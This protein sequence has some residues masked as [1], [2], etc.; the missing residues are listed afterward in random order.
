M[1]PVYVILAEG[2]EEIE[3]LTVVDI[4]RRG[5]VFVSTVSNTE[6]KFVAG[7]HQI[8]VKADLI[9]SEMKEEE[10]LAIV[11]PGG[12]PGTI[13]L[14]ENEKLM[15]M[16]KRRHEKEELLA[17]ICAAPALILG[18][19]E[20]IKGRKATCF[21]TMTEYLKEANYQPDRKVV[22]DGHI[23]TGCGMGGAI[24]F[25]LQILEALKGKEVA[26]KIQKSIVY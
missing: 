9:F 12:M 25:G 18:D 26:N 20:I 13:H 19:L 16:V 24:P 7:S 22:Q 8:I 4:L 5:E 6:E 21:P 10:A 14:K 3:A 17:A 23:I 2:F 1:K 15:E 11:L